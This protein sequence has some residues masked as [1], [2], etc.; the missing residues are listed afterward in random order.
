MSKRADKAVLRAKLNVF[1]AAT[2]LRNQIVSVV[3]I[4]TLSVDFSRYFDLAEAICGR[5][6][7]LLPELNLFSTIVP[8]EPAR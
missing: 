8:N 4:W 5:F 7:Q 3:L 6:P 1:I 2:E